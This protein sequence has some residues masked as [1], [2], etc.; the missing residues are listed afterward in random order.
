MGHLIY[1]V[2]Y[3][4]YSRNC[5]RPKKNL[6]KKKKVKLNQSC[7][8]YVQKWSPKNQQKE[9]SIGLKLL[10][11]WPTPQGNLTPKSH[12]SAMYPKLLNLHKWLGETYRENH[13]LTRSVLTW[14]QMF[15][16]KLRKGHDLPIVFLEV[17]WQKGIF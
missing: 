11:K 10:E 8:M 9:E 1:D 3:E 6:K 7:I 5:S 14:Q 13:Y 16:Y 4:G 12:E 2:S 17:A 15:V